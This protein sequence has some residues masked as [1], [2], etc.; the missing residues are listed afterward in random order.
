MQTNEWMAFR[1]IH[2]LVIIFVEFEKLWWNEIVV[3]WE[4]ADEE[5]IRHSNIIFIIFHGANFC[6]RRVKKKLR[7]GNFFYEYINTAAVVYFFCCMCL[8]RWLCMYWCVCES[9]RAL[10]AW[11]CAYA[12]RLS[13]TGNAFNIHSKLIHTY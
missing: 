3:V 12:C 8:L 6:W 11:M 13:C 5:N 4:R 9:F 1:W 2:F 7:Q 10:T